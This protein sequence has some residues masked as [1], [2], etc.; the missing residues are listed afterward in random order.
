M[1]EQVPPTLVKKQPVTLICSLKAT[2]IQ[3]PSVF[4]E[5]YTK[6]IHSLN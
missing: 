2:K 1:T 3:A 4:I 5:M 6:F